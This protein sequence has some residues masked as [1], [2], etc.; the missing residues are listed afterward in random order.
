M[1]D[2]A[3]ESTKPAVEAFAADSLQKQQK[4]EIVI[5]QQA[6]TGTEERAFCFSLSG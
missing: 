2:D 5:N 3:D 1:Q 4:P 6:K